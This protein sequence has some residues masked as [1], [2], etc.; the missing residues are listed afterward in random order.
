MTVEDLVC[1][2]R[3][4][5]YAYHNDDGSIDIYAPLISA[6]EIVI[7][8]SRNEIIGFSL[9]SEREAWLSA[10]KEVIPEETLAYHLLFWA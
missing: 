9:V 2:F 1:K 3:P 6:N 5:A 4:F 8:I 7:D 10:A